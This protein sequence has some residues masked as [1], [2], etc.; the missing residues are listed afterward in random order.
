MVIQTNFLKKE[1]GK[2]IAL[3]GIDFV[4][5]Y[6]RIKDKVILK[7]L[8]NI[9]CFELDNEYRRTNNVLVSV[10]IAHKIRLDFLWQRFLNCMIP[11]YFIKSIFKQ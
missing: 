8:E 9:P 1:R 7:K 3:K 11:K 10:Y 2:N 5:R 4:K 6:C